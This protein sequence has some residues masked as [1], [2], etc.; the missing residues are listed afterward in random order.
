MASTTRRSKASVL[1]GV[2]VVVAAVPVS[3]VLVLGP[4]LWALITRGR[5]AHLRI[6]LTPKPAPADGPGVLALARRIA[7]R[8]MEDFRAQEHER[9]TEADRSAWTALSSIHASSRPGDRIRARALAELAALRRTRADSIEREAAL[10]SLIRIAEL[11]AAAAGDNC[12]HEP[13]EPRCAR[14][15]QYWT[16]FH[17]GARHR[18]SPPTRDVARRRL[19]PSRAPASHAHVEPLRG[20]R[21]R[22]GAPAH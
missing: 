8:T 21:A 4:P 17:R 16:R 9:L 15:A 11:L 6:D 7:W 14:P 18:S 12:L 20:L 3:A 22:A 5:R 19:A 13:R 1:R 10:A 2:L